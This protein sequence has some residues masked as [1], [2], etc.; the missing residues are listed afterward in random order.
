MP[1]IIGHLLIVVAALQPAAASLQPAATN[2]TGKAEAP[3][4]GDTLRVRDEQ[5]KLHKVKIQGIDAP[6]DGQPFFKAARDHLAKVTQERELQVTEL[7]KDAAGR[8]LATIR[9]K[10]QDLRIDILSAGMAWHQRS[11][12][13]D[14][15]L[16]AE[17][18]GAKARHLGLWID[19]DPVAPWEWRAAEEQ[20]KNQRKPAEKSTQQGGAARG[21]EKN[22]P[23][24]RP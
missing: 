15:V 22:I 20:R 1:A 21:G 14:P 4:D 18:R 10:G 12:V 16:E 8:T 17:E 9:I 23:P 13:E 5:D 2:W 11:V 24:G 3:I 19:I 7:G 6:E